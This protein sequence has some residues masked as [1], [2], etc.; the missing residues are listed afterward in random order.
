M[1]KIFISER[2]VSG[3]QISPF[4]MM[5][6]W[7]LNV[8][9]LKKY[10]SRSEYTLFVNEPGIFMKFL[11]RSAIRHVFAH[12]IEACIR[13]IVQWLALYEFQQHWFGR[14]LNNHDSKRQQEFVFFQ[15]HC[16]KQNHSDSD[17]L[18]G[19]PSL[20]TLR[21]SSYKT[22]LC[23]VSQDAHQKHC[24][25]HYITWVPAALVWSR[26]KKA[27]LNASAR[28]TSISW[29]TVENKISDSDAL[30]EI[31]SV[32]E[33]GWEVSAELRGLVFDHSPNGHDNRK[34]IGRNVPNPTKR[35]RPLSICAQLRSKRVGHEELIQCVRHFAIR[36]APKPY[37]LLST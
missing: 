21:S 3:S 5:S 31:A 32:L 7:K 9:R 30:S 20:I 10:G 6:P 29:S 1:S 26:N 13:K 4:R 19:Q 2:R 12:F 36:M 15:G 33:L 18:P 28:I 23:A 35:L 11:G 16:W 14:E 34:C 25:M 37:L 24:V 22:W 8:S 17:A 27:R